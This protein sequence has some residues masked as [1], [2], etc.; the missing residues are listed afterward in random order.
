MVGLATGAIPSENVKLEGN[1]L[2][3]EVTHTQ[4]SNNLKEQNFFK[5][6][7]RNNQDEN[8]WSDSQ[9]SDRSEDDFYNQEMRHHTIARKRK[10]AETVQSEIKF[11]ISG[12]Q[13]MRRESV[14]SDFLG[15][16]MD[17]GIKADHMDLDDFQ[18]QKYTEEQKKTDPSS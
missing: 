9:E 14:I 15:A 18:E 4:K 10:R 7:V 8:T 17:D 13:E 1:Y 11:E 16:V 2:Q 12:K 5:E 3:T 6:F